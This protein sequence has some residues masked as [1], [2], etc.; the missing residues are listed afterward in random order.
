MFRGHAMRVAQAILT[1]LLA[2]A[3]AWAQGWQVPRTPDGAPDLQGV[4]STVTATP[5]ERPAAFSGLTT[6][7]EGE[8]AFV[9]QSVKAFLDDESDGIGGRQSEWWEV[10]GEMLRIGGAIRT[11]VIVE[12]A[13]GRM[14]YS[15]AGKARLA[16]ALSDNLNVYDHP[17]ARPATERCLAGGSGSTGVPIFFVRYNANYQF[18]QTKD[19]LVISMEQAGQVRIIPLHDEPRSGTRRWMGYSTGRWEGDTLVVETDG[20]VIGDAYKP[21]APILVSENAKVTERFTRIAPGELLYQFTVDDPDVFTQV[22]RGET[23]FHT[24][25]THVME[26]ACHEGNHSL[27]NILGGGREIDRKKGG[28]R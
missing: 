13:S 7:E 16:K 11:S 15:E 19:H 10:S 12:P 5:L 18:V 2:A 6:T 21:A 3:P 27:T 9:Q 26:S 23:V 20:F 25:P 4:W 8:K 1:I 14:P 24:V 22:W 17:E 28:G